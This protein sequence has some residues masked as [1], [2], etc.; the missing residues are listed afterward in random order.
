MLR[1]QP[2]SCKWVSDMG[3]SPNAVNYSTC[4]PR[5]LDPRKHTCLEFFGHSVS[6]LYVA[7]RSWTVH[8]WKCVFGALIVLV[9]RSA[10][11]W[12]FAVVVF[13]MR[14]FDVTAASE[15]HYRV[16]SCV[17]MYST[18]GHFHPRQC[19]KFAVFGCARMSGGSSMSTS[20]VDVAHFRCAHVFSFT[21]TSLLLSGKRF[22]INVFKLFRTSTIWDATCRFSR[23]LSPFRRQ[24]W[25]SRICDD[26]RK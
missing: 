11:M 14:T 7:M 21:R 15:A 3:V 17:D 24:F 4:G 5:W 6:P 16:Q 1:R 19:N 26:G 10:T 13:I 12:K 8:F 9:S 20:L 18:C 23:P 22:H 2:G 25:Q